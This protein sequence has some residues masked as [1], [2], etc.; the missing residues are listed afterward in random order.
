MTSH[1]VS[2]RAVPHHATGT[3]P[4]N[5]TYLSARHLGTPS[6]NPHEQPH[7]RVGSGSPVRVQDRQNDPDPDSRNDMRADC[8]AGL[9]VVG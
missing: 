6:E 1:R 3:T 9:Y 2:Y 8:D 5:S 4:N 7:P